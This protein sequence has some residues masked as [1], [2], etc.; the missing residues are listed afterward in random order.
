[1]EKV[2]PAIAELRQ[3]ALNGSGYFHVE[4]EL[5]AYAT[6]AGNWFY[7]RSTSC[8]YSVTVRSDNAMGRPSSRTGSGW[9]AIGDVW[10]MDDVDVD[11]LTARAA[12]K[13]RRSADP[14][15]FPLGRYTVVLEP[16]AAGGFIQ[17]L[18]GALR[19]AQVGQLITSDRI[20]LRS[21]P[22][23]PLLMASPYG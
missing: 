1:M 17:Q 15:P 14:Q 4:E 23:H 9:A 20:T 13:A 19:G 22:D 18:A 16:S 2:A 12:D 7:R 11:G 10:R 3:K 6:S 8:G 5:E 21:K